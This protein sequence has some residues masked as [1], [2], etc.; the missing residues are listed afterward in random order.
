MSVSVGGSTPPD[1][2]RRT[3]PKAW[4]LRGVAF[5]DQLSQHWIKVFNPSLRVI[6]LYQNEGSDDD[7]MFVTASPSES[8]PEALAL[9]ICRSQRFFD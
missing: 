9:F 2:L 8:S 4:A 1:N 7:Y 5:S 3:M 6:W